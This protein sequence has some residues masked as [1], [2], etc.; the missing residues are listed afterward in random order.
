ML[1]G[2]HWDTDGAGSDAVNLT[3]RS[4]VNEGTNPTVHS[5]VIFKLEGPLRVLHTVG[6]SNPVAGEWLVFGNASDFYIQRTILSGT[7]EVDDI[8]AGWQQLG[9]TDFT[10][11]NQSTIPFS[12]KLTEV[13]YEISTDVSGIPVIETATHSYRSN[14][15]I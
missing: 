8:G 7:L 3:N 4:V 15:D 9:I 11:D 2:Q 13:F 1:V 6:G 14:K 12:F 5:G 10:M